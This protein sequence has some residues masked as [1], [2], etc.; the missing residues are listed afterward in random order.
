[1]R[2]L[3]ILAGA[4]ALATAAF[5]AE[6]PVAVRQTLMDGNG[7]AAALAAGVMKDE[8]P[9]S[10][11]VGNAVIGSFAATAA[12]FGSFFPEG[13]AGGD[14]TAAPKIWEDPAG[15]QSELEKF[16]TAA[17]AARAAAGKDGP[18][19]KAAFVAAVQPIFD[20]CKTCHETY[21]IRK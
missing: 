15:F 7:S 13:S 9:Y 20:T 11:A 5:A 18:A 12:A 19:D 3:P 2:S 14:S 1:M 4:L 10:P 8:V 16:A 17:N 6:D 21:R